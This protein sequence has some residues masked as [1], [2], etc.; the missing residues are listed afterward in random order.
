[1]NILYLKYAVEVARIGSIN[2][3][4]EE[5][6][7]A[8]PNLSRAIKELEKELGIT[9][10]DRNSKGMTLTPDGERLISYGR[11]ILGE[12]EEVEEMFKTGESKKS[13][14]T[15]SVPRASYISYAFARFTERLL[16]ISHCSSFKSLSVNR[17]NA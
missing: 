15:V 2:K 16:N 1:M 9:V 10:F 14:L 11:K 17:A 13:T 3:A 5:L 12:I 7:V 8:Q 6:F 4:A